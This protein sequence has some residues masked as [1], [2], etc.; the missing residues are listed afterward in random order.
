MKLRV[1]FLSIFCTAIILFSG[2]A[3]ALTYQ[4]RT[5]VIS[6]TTNATKLPTTPLVGREYVLIQNIGS[7][8]VYLGNSTVTADTEATGGTQL[9]PQS[10][11][12]AEY[13][14]SVDIYG[15][16]AAATCKVVVEEGK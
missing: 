8:T 5:Q 6:V 10:I 4:I 15:I 11:Y 13:D 7:V 16:V 1:K 9:L 2:I 12:V 3:F 14:N